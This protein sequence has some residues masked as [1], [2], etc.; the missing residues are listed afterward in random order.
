MAENILATPEAALE[1]IFGGTAL[2]TMTSGK[3]G[4]H[5]TFKMRRGRGDNAP[6][7]ANVLTGSPDNWQD[8]DFIGFVKLSEDGEKTCLMAGRKGKPD[9][10]SFKAL[11][12]ALAHLHR[13]EM[14]EALTIQHEGRCCRC[15][16]TLTHPDSIESGIGPECAKQGAS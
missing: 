9:A 16:R 5:F 4:N 12:W 6:W 7:F 1:F 10:P 15:N 14:P 2:F 11:S 8:F 3:T 13:G